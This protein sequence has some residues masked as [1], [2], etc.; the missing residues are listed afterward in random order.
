MRKVAAATRPFDQARI[1]P[2]RGSMVGPQCSETNISTQTCVA[3]TN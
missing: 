2:I 1:M 3:T